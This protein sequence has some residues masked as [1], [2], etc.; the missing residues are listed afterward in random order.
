MSTSLNLGSLD[1][2]AILDALPDGA[3]VT[4]RDRRIVFWNRAAEQITGWRRDDVLG[5]CCRDNI[6]CHVDKDGHPL[7]GHE[8]CP[9]HRAMVTGTR[10]EAP[11]LLFAQSK[12]GRRIP[13]EVSVSPLRTD[14]GEVIGGIEVFR[15]LTPAFD[16]LNRARLIQRMALSLQLPEDP[17]VDF[18]VRYTPH[19]EVGGD[20]YRIEALDAD[21]YAILVAD[22]RGH[23]VPSALYAMQLR[24]LWDD[25]RPSLG[26]PAAFLSFLNQRAVALVEHEGGYFATALHVAYNAAT[27]EMACASA[28]HPAPF[29]VRAGN[30]IDALNVKGPALGLV[31]G[32]AYG[33]FHANV[34]PGSALLLY[35]DGAFEVLNAAN[36]ELLE[37]GLR[38]IVGRQD[39]ADGSR[40]LCAIEESLLLYSNNLSLPDDLTLFSLYRPPAA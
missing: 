15:D 33:A 18:S 8:H 6:L 32:A 20:F 9:L 3:Y 1:S 25:A 2:V 5:H 14:A 13:V 37:D 30:R 31:P 35:T 34:A 36:E 12:D 24:T 28:G 17:R 40:T 38:K 19:D 7:C 4:D 21:R 27:G 29:L 26:D 39:F 22:V 23:G 11:R 10:S 16:D